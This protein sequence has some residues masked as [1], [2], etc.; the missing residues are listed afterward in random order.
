MPDLFFGWIQVL[1]QKSF[2]G[3]DLS[4][5]AKAALDCAGFQ[6]CLLNWMKLITDFQTFESRDFF[7]TT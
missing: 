7:I 2:G 3:Q 4:R 6:K 5:G 1:I